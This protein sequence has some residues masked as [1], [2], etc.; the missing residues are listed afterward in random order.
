MNIKDNN[1]EINEN[2]MCINRYIKYISLSVKCKFYVNFLIFLHN[3]FNNKRINMSIISKG[4]IEI[5]P[6]GI[7]FL[8]S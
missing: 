5:N 4:I 3:S 7:K 2:S 1:P 8:K 6:P